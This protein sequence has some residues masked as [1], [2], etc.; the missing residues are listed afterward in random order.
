MEQEGVIMESAYRYHLRAWKELH[1]PSLPE[2]E[3][4]RRKH[5]CKAAIKQGIATSLTA[6][7]IGTAVVVK[8]ATRYDGMSAVYIA[9]L[10]IIMVAVLGCILAYT[11]GTRMGLQYGSYLQ[12]YN[13]DY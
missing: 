2:A 10:G 7:I 1:L 9:L 4:S 11:I 8:V 12:R 3:V 5:I 6:M 13:N